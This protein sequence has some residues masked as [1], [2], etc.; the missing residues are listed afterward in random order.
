MRTGLPISPLSSFIMKHLRRL[1]SCILLVNT[2]AELAHAAFPTIYLKNVCDDQLHA[3]TNI[4]N[5]G[6]GSQRLFICDQPGKIFIFQHHMLLPVPFLD[7]TTSGSGKIIPAP[8]GYSERGLLGMCFH[9]GHADPMSPG[10]RR[11]YVHYNAPPTLPTLNPVQGGATTN[12]VSVIAEYLVSTTNPNSADPNSERVLL[13]L[14]QPQANHNGGQIEFGPDGLLYIALGDGGGAND[15]AIGHTGGTAPSSPAR[16]TGTLGNGQDVSVLWGKILRIDPLGSNG[17]SGQYG[18]PAGNP[19]YDGSEAHGADAEREEIYAWGLRNPWRFSF[20]AT[21]GGPNSL[22]CADVGQL[23]VEEIDLI[24]NGGNYG[25]R[26]KEGTLDFDGTAPAGPGAL[27]APIAAYAHPLALLGHGLLP[28]SELLPRYGSSITGGYVYR[29]SAIPSMVGKY[30]FADY[31]ENGISGGNGVFLGLEETSPGVFVMSEVDTFSPLPASSRIYC[32]GKDEAG[33][34]FVATKTTSGVLTQDGSKPAGTLWQIVTGGTATLA[35]PPSKDNTLYQGS[36]TSNGKGPHVYSGKTGSSAGYAA[37][38]ALLRFDL[39][40]IPPEA[41]LTGASLELSTTLQITQDV[42]FF[43]HKVLADW[44]EGNSNAGEP[45]GGG[46]TAQVGD[47]TWVRRFYN[48]QSWASQGGDFDPLPSAVRNVGN[49]FTDPKP[50][51][52][53]PGLLADVE[54]WRTAPATNFGWILVGDE[55]ELN[56]NPRAMRFGSREN[57]SAAARPRLLVSY[58]TLPAPTHFEAWLAA[59]YA[60]LP[61]GSYVDPSADDDRDSLPNLVE[62]AY[63]FSPGIGQDPA[64]GLA[65]S[66][67]NDGMNTQLTITFRR[68]PRATD[69]NYELEAMDDQGVWTTL[70]TSLAGTVTT[71]AGVQGENVI[72]GQSPVRSVTVLEELPGLESQ[73]FVRLRISRAP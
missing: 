72:P 42:D 15:N 13:T 30:L 57:P 21:F 25:W 70:A 35:I 51:W 18:I 37:R 53:G 4:T 1:L 67:S 66:L 54:A 52:T 73:R 45:G 34:L 3:P 50:T 47:A 63:A 31:A 43:L 39:S 68:D 55:D 8:T 69:L 46:A 36:T 62:Y 6:D 58:S 64:D 16:E 29:G 60:S 12:C 41:A 5:A 22:I 28:G 14:G 33:E 44:G 9:P 49:M 19:F 56:P 65:L 11:F 23:D 59:H 32:F 10:Y 24:T 20:D 48:T 71:G 17:Q 38:R 26:V 40:T 27:V 2:M 7:L 61:P